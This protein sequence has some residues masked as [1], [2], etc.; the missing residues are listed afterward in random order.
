MRSKR[1]ERLHNE[2]RQYSHYRRFLI[3]EFPNFKKLFEKRTI[4]ILIRMLHDSM[5]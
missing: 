3:T 2:F 1:N 4:A 5:L